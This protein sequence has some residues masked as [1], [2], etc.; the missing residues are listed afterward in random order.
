M[1]LQLLRNYL[2]SRT[3]PVCAYLYDLAHLRR[4]VAGRIQHLRTGDYVAFLLAS[5]YGWNIFHHDFLSHPHP[6]R[7][8]VDDG[9]CTHFL[10]SSTPI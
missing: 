9:I 6:E 1:N 3:E 10:F 8:C 4:R 5:A 7:V 2:D